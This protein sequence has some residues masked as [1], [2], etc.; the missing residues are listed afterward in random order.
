MEIDVKPQ[1]ES[2]G[3]RD[4]TP[5]ISQSKLAFWSGSGGSIKPRISGM[6]T[7]P[8]K[9]LYT[10]TLV[11]RLQVSRWTT[12]L[13]D[14][15]E[16]EQRVGLQYAQEGREEGGEE[17]GEE[18][19]GYTCGGAAGRRIHYVSIVAALDIPPPT[20]S[21]LRAVRSSPLPF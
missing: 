11:H 1:G 2:W 9:K 21:L 4:Q 16:L 17:G 7:N 5:C 15:K 3:S 14:R 18:E 12:E 6:I 10:L 20:L 19:E 8:F 13:N